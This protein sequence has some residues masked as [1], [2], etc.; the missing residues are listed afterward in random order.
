MRRN[1]AGAALAVGVLGC[2]SVDATEHCVETRYGKIVTERMPQGLNWTPVTEAN[3]FTMTEQNYPSGKVEAEDGK[4]YQKGEVIAAQTADPITVTGDVAISYQFIPES[5]LDVFKAKRSQ[6]NAEQEIINAIR[7]GYRNALS[8]Y[9]IN[10]GPNM[11]FANRE[12]VADAV[13]QAIQKK[14]TYG[15]NADGTPKY[16]ARIINVFV[17]DIKVPQQIEAA[18]IAAVTQAQ[19]LD[20]ARSQFVID[21]VGARTTVMTASANAEAKRLE[22]QSYAA[23]PQLL[24]LEIAKQQAMGMS[25]VCRASTTCILGGSVLDKLL[26]R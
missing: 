24:G 8:K 16:R 19:V 5:I 22:A 7:E 23:N 17:R 20:K 12:G 6:D 1:L 18:R 3:C 10:P 15:A 26:Q 25:N 11:I 21:S 13:R 14:L 2:T 4:E 9:T